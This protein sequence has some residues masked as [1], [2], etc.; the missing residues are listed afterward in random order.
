[1]PGPD[2][3]YALSYAQLQKIVEEVSHRVDHSCS[4][5]IIPFPSTFVLDS[6]NRQVE[7]TIRIRISHWRGVDQP[8]GL[9]EQHA[10][11]EIENELHGLGITRR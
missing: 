1:M 8:A 4:L 3:H 7:A 10:F 5:E 2:P 6:R 9:P 11:E